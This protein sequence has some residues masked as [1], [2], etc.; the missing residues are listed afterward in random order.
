MNDVCTVGV[1]ALILVGF[2][3]IKGPPATPEQD[4]EKDENYQ[5]PNGNIDPFVIHVF[6][7]AQ[8]VVTSL[9]PK[10]IWPSGL[11]TRHSPTF[12]KHK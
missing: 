7:S 9:P 11:R 10:L 5:Q 2:P 6:F 4:S 12:S 3:P 1:F 8:C